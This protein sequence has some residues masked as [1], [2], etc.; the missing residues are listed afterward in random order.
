MNLTLN[1]H[2]T[3]ALIGYAVGIAANNSGCSYGPVYLQGVDL[4]PCGVDVE[5]IDMIY[6]RK[7]GD[8]LAALKPIAEA[9]ERVS[10]HTY[11]LTKEH[12]PFITVGGDHTCA[13]GSWSG[14]AA[15][16]R[17]QGPIG[18]IWIDAHMDSHTFATTKSNNI[19]GMPLAALLG[20]GESELTNIL[21]NQAKLFPENIC[22]IGVRSFESG[23]A[24]LL[25]KLGVKIFFIEEVE[26]EEL[27]SVMQQA[28]KIVSA[29][30]VGFGI[31]IDLDAFDPSEVPAVCTSVAHGMH[32]NPFLKTVD[33][34]G[35][36]NKLLG[37]D[38]AGFEP[39]SDH[40]NLTLNVIKSIIQT[41]YG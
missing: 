11:A 21:D 2:K 35:K 6:E 31:S 16:L 8:G 39:N 30:T 4:A 40:D 38:I 29:N 36:N 27:N 41:I 5:W 20:Y 37:I 33:N 22:L 32:V 10:H 34:I 28:L 3:I 25:K 23:E 24:E 1:Q 13:I 12:K 19:H 15:A 9:C 7:Q 17:E 14:A 26:R 18:L